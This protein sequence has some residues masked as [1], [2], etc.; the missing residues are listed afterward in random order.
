MNGADV[1]VLIAGGGPVGLFLGCSLAQAGV[2]LAVLE[3]RQTINTGSRSIGIHP[4]ALERF[5][6]LGLVEELLARGIKVRRGQ[7]FV[8]TRLIGTLDFTALPEPY[9]YVLTLPQE[10]TEELLRQRLYGLRPEA[11]RLGASVTAIEQD[12]L[13][14]TVLYQQ[15]GHRRLRGRYLVACDGKRSLVRQQLAI[16]WRGGS[17]PD[18]YLMGD[19]RDDSSLGDDAAI[20]L[21]DAGVVES[22]PLPGGLR[23][24]VVKT[25][26]Y[27][28]GATAADL[29]GLLAARLGIAVASASATMVSAFGVQRYLAGRL[30]AG[31][32]ILAGDAAHVVS[33]IG[34][35][36]MNL[37][38]LDAAHLA[39]LLP[40][41]LRGEAGVDLATYQ[42]Q[43]QRATRTAI[44]RAEFNMC[45]GRR[46]RYPGLRHT[47]VRAM[48]RPSLAGLLARVFTMDGLA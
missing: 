43:R 27:L 37:G 3:Q 18:T 48:L 30:V 36:G 40:R 34:G 47:A 13:G 28:K 19:V 17:Y 24:W 23:R 15:G 21:C 44:R 7:A 6:T 12:G 10:Q 41:L 39:E 38:W 14:V 22:F 1:E 32:V 2:S 45:L 4:P 33:P 29:A 35:Q 8:N 42:Q 16:S 25:E 20:Y 31:R 9:R 46:W 5:A 26:H 11:L